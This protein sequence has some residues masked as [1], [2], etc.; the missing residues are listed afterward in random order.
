MTSRK[1]KWKQGWRAKSWL[2]GQHCPES[3]P[4]RSIRVCV[5]GGASRREI[6]IKQQLNAPL[7]PL[8]MRAA[9]CSTS[10]MLCWFHGGINTTLSQHPV[11]PPQPR[12]T[13]STADY[14]ISCLL[15]HFKP[16]DKHS[17]QSGQRAFGWRNAHS[18][19]HDGG[20]WRVVYG[21][22]K[23]EAQRS[24]S[25]SILLHTSCVTWPKGRQD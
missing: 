14:L 16:T 12:C 20:P 7:I 25:S 21:C 4:G 6:I 2:Y 24:K 18:V 3:Q 22:P 15:T 19:G 1:E 9:R 23:L 10:F 17:C 11:Q 5:V 8:W 13:A